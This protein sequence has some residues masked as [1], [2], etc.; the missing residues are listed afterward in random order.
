MSEIVLRRYLVRASSLVLPLVAACA[1]T[2]PDTN[3]GTAFPRH[4]P[5][6]APSEIASHHAGPAKAESKSAS[7]DIDVKLEHGYISQD[8]AE[9]AVMARW[10]E[11]TNCYKR[12][13]A[14]TDFASGGVTLRFLVN[15]KGT[16]TEV[17]IID[18]R[19]GSFEVERC[20]IA[21]GQSTPFPQPQGGAI[22]NVDYTMEFRS[23]GQI[24]VM[25]LPAGEL[26]AQ[27][28]ALLTRLNRDCARPSV[29]EISATLYIDSGG[30]VRSV[31]LASASRLDE[32]T[33]TCLSTSIQGWIIPTDA[34]RGHGLGRITVDLHGSDLLARR[35]PVRYTRPGP[36][37]S[38]PRRPAH[39]R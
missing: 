36:S 32:L 18:T 17:R 13:R 9:D 7:D 25:D 38:R 31:G 34:L 10:N 1:T 35:D 33:A 23:T 15:A 22:A 3:D 28:P 29:E 4:E 8:A 39:R 2:T 27:L 24:P 19:L 5:R 37:R 20:L 11:L 12:A 26:D 6:R 30:A 16:A 21:V 14:A